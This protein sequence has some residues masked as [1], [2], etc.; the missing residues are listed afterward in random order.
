MLRDWKRR[1]R[2]AHDS[3]LTAM[4][5]Y[6]VWCAFACC[7][8][9]VVGFVFFKSICRQSFMG[10]IFP[11]YIH[12]SHSPWD[13]H[14]CSSGSTGRI[15]NTCQCRQLYFHIFWNTVETGKNNIQGM[16]LCINRNALPCCG[17]CFILHSIDQDMHTLLVIYDPDTALSRTA[18]VNCVPKEL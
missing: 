2:H 9:C 17:V 12:H 7:K 4:S 15:M 16:W 11:K 5:P 8:G 3:I 18:A 13:F 14:P 1:E 10:N 6:G